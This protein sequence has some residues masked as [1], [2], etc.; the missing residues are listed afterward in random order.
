[1]IPR[2][3][4]LRRWDLHCHRCAAGS[5]RSAAFFRLRGR[6][7]G[8]S[9]R[10]CGSSTNSS[11]PRH[12]P[13]RGEKA[14]CCLCA[15][16]AIALEQRAQ[17]VES[18]EVIAASRYQHQDREGTRADDPAIAAPARGRADS[19][20][21][22]RQW[23]SSSSNSLGVCFSGDATVRDGPAGAASWLSKKLVQL[24]NVL[25]PQ[26]ASRRLSCGR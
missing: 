1:M 10:S 12:P 2:P 26:S 25:L 4:P 8:R 9:S 24:P 19:M 18:C 5:S 23:V 14:V 15:T 17:I 3:R 16:P 6:S 7:A 11:S 22:H 20:I 21:A 13:C